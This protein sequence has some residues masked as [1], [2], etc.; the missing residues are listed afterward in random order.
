[1][2]DCL[3]V[4]CMYLCTLVECEELLVF[5]LG[6]LGDDFAPSKLSKVPMEDFSEML[7]LCFCLLISQIVGELE[8][9]IKAMGTTGVCC[10]TL[11]EWALLPTI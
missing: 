7:M 3:A 11:V 9:E 2:G 5:I 1:M 10:F 6:L 8:P 4:I